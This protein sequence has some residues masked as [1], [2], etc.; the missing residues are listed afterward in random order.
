MLP[1]GA[2]QARVVRRGQH[3]E[4]FT[5]VIFGEHARIEDRY[6]A[7]AQA[8]MIMPNEELFDTMTVHVDIPPEDMPGRPM[9]RIQCSVC[10]EY[11]QDMREVYRNSQILC[12]ACAEGT[13]Y[14]HTCENSRHAARLAV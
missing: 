13:Y 9:R 6:E 10:G 4:E 7:Q 8:Y 5:A 12:K 1:A 2:G 14:H 11:V 3:G